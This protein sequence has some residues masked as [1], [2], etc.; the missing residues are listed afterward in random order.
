VQV[1]AAQP[2]LDAFAGDKRPPAA[3]SRTATVALDATIRRRFKDCNFTTGPSTR[4]AQN[5]GGQRRMLESPARKAGEEQL[6]GAITL[7]SH[8]RPGCCFG[9]EG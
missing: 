6:V 7:D 1:P 5:A 4:W 9:I 2:V 3:P 8:R